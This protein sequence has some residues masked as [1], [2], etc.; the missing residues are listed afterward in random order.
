VRNRRLFTTLF[1]SL[2]WVSQLVLSQT[3]G[4]AGTTASQASHDS[5]NP[6]DTAFNDVV[7]F[8]PRWFTYFQAVSANKLVGPD[9]I[10]PIY[11]VVI[12]INVD[13]LN[14]GAFFSLTNEPVIVISHK[15]DECSSEQSIELT[16]LI[17]QR[18]IRAVAYVTSPRGARWPTSPSSLSAVTHSSLRDP[19][20]IGG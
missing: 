9:R 15:A 14:A 18:K 19:F 17:A 8:Y 13:T 10:S 11:H 3:S 6:F 16:P 7:T 5:A 2:L 4:A 1:L 12:A 20:F